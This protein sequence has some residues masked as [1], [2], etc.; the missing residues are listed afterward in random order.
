METAMTQLMRP[1]L[2]SVL[3]CVSTTLNA[4]NDS[5]TIEDFSFLAGYWSGEGF[6]GKSEEMWTPPAT[7]HRSRNIL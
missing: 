3:L 1:L 2:L 6:G 4:D 5:V 7:S